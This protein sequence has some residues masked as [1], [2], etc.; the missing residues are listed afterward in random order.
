[1]S[2]YVLYAM[3][4]SDSKY[5]DLYMESLISYNKVLEN[6]KLLSQELGIEDSLSLS[7]LFS[8]MLWNGYYSVSKTHS[9]KLQDRLLLPSMHSFD[10]IKGGGVCLAYAELLHNYLT[11]CDKKSSLLDC[12]CPTGKNDISCS[13]RPEIERS[14]KNSFSGKTL[15][16]I[17][18]L[19]LR[20]L[21][22]K[23]GN[24]SV[25]LI[26]ED[27]KLFIYDPTNLYVLNVVSENTA[28]II[29]GSGNFQI[30][31]FSTLIMKPDSDDNRLFERLVSGIEIA[32]AFT[33]REIIFSFENIIELINNNINMLDDAYD[34]IHSELEIIDRQ[35]DEIGGY[36]NAFR[37][38]RRM[39]KK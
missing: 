38:I 26:E 19:L 18:V 39:E 21:V 3:C 12:K 8:Y 29:N 34:N 7:H 9:Y 37:K 16:Q 5:K 23:T 6:Y 2:S 30:K 31:P 13:Y 33:R 10:V 25:T 20:G 35:T 4:D 27:D 14:I 15:Y 28:S 1:M 24:H 36:F 11:V 32:P 17:L 22:N